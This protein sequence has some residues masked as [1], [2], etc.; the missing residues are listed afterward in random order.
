MVNKCESVIKTVSTNKRKWLITRLTKMVIEAGVQLAKCELVAIMLLGRELAPNPTYFFCGTWKPCIA[1]VEAGKFVVKQVYGSA[2]L[3][4]W[5]KQTS[6]YNGVN[7]N[8]SN[9]TRKRA[10]VQLVFYCKRV[11]RINLMEKSK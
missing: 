2:G 6:C 10:Y 4:G 7:T 11:C 5:K 9:L 3:R 1:P 8:S